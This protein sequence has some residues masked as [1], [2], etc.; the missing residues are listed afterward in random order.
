MKCAY[1][2]MYCELIISSSLH[3]YHYSKFVCRYLSLLGKH[4]VI[5]KAVTSALLTL[6]GDVICQVN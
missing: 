5:T 1:A 6:V 4:P 3:P 2:C